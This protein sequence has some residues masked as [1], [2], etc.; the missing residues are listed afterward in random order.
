MKISPDLRIE[1]TSSRPTAPLPAPSA[2]ACGPSQQADQVHLDAPLAPPLALEPEVQGPPPST[3]DMA[4]LHLAPLT[5]TNSGSGPE[6]PST[7]VMLEPEVETGL[8]PLPDLTPADA[9]AIGAVRQGLE[10]HPILARVVESFIMDK[11]HP[12]N[13][14]AYLKDVQSRPV[15]LEHLDRMARLCPVGPSGLGNLVEQ[16][17][18]PEV[19]LLTESGAE[20]GTRDGV[21]GPQRLR[22]QLIDR[23]PELFS[24]GQPESEEEWGRLKAHA[25]FLRTEVLPGLTGELESLVADLPNS[26]GF[27]AVNAR[28]KSAAGM[29]DK[30]DRMQRGNDGKAPRPDYCLADMPDAVGGRITVRDPRQLQQVMDRLEERFGKENIFEKDNFYANPKKRLRPYRCITYTVVHQGVPCEVQLTTLNSSLA[31]DLWH[32]TGY[33]P[34]HPELT[35]DEIGYLGDLQCSVSADEHR[36][37]GTGAN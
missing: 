20:L 23:D 11:D 3:P 17:F 27:P 30:I 13:L 14:V 36:I 22:Q 33:K 29:A 10:Q 35:G 24:M 9:Q 28:A 31:A 18:N 2:P 26:G 1:A 16:T 34:L 6:V 5:S 19:P 15:V 12:M 25:S 8:P 4:S 37:L 7:M 21:S 32:N